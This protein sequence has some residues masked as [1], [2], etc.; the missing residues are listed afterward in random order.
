MLPSV[1][2]TMKAQVPGLGRW[3]ACLSESSSACGAGR[4]GTR[5]NPGGGSGGGGSEVTLSS[6]GGGSEDDAAAG[7]V[8]RSC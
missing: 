4:L 2:R 5:C 8:G 7:V 6:G 3:T 1:T